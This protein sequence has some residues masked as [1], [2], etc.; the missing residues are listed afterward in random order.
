MARLAKLLPDLLDEEQKRLYETITAGPRA[1]GR[2][3]WRNWAR[4][5]FSSSPLWSVLRHLGASASRLPGG[6][7]G[8][9]TRGAPGRRETLPAA[10]TGVARAHYAG[11]RHAGTS[12]LPGR[13]TYWAAALC[14]WSSDSRRDS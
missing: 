6:R 14:R 11:W 2:Q 12:H 1:D 3:P 9:V 8:P 13:V 5:R 4:R 7:P 10:G